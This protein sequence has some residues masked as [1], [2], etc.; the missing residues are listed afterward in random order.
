MVIKKDLKEYLHFSSSKIFNILKFSNRIFF[1]P[2]VFISPSNK[3][4]FDCLMCLYRKSNIRNVEMMDF[5][6]VEKIVSEC[7]RFLFK[8]LLHF[9]GQ[10]EPLIYPK[11]RKAMQLCN[12]FKMKWSVTSNG[13]FL[14][15][16]AKDLVVDNCHAINVSIHGNSFEND[17]ITG[18]NGSFD[19]AINSIKKLEEIKNQ[20]KMNTPIVSIN[21]VITNYNVANLWNILDSFLKLPVNSINFEHLHFSENDLKESCPTNKAIVRDKNINELMKF[22]SFLKNEKFPINVF[23][24]PKIQK[25]D[26]FG[27]Y[28]DKYYDFNDSCNF[29]WLSVFVK[30]DGSVYSCSQFIGD[31]NRNSLKEIVNSKKAIEF[32]DRIRRGLRPKPS[33]CF[34]CTHIQYY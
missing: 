21:C 7:S 24:Y 32:R 5:S 23:F 2:V 34:R 29:P 33:G 28:A 1:L 6:L 30:P 4:N 19:R 10:G 16:Y 9:S 14:E 11:I 25:K 20:F 8:P 3:C 18:V 31:L 15:K 13:Y 27:Y 17:E 12:E 26:M 22:S